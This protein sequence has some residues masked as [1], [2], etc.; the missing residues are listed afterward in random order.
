[1]LSQTECE[2]LPPQSMHGLP[3]SRCHSVG[4][5]HLRHSSNCPQIS[6]NFS[7][8]FSCA[9]TLLHCL[10]YYVDD[11]P[12]HICIFSFRTLQAR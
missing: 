9:R 10:G 8:F 5:Q 4:D 11:T 1:M 6:V 3:Q 7:P 12:Y 2:Y